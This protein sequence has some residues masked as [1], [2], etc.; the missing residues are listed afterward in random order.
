M[1]KSTTKLESIFPLLRKIF[2]ILWKQKDGHFSRKSQESLNKF[3]LTKGVRRKEIASGD[4]YARG[5]ALRALRLK[6]RPSALRQQESKGH[7]AL[8]EGWKRKKRMIFFGEVPKMILRGKWAQR[9]SSPCHTKRGRAVK[10]MA[11]WIFS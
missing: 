5:A 8:S 2:P 1:Q 10:R 9:I 7:R 11:H 4:R 6:D 3:Y